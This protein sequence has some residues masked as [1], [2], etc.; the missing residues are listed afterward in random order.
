MRTPN[1]GHAPPC[2]SSFL[3][4]GH[5]TACT[6]SPVFREHRMVPYERN[7]TKRNETSHPSPFSCRISDRH[8]SSSLFLGGATAEEPRHAPVKTKQ[9]TTYILF[10][11]SVVIRTTEREREQRLERL[12]LPLPPRDCHSVGGCIFLACPPKDVPLFPTDCRPLRCH[13]R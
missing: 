5:T 2:R 4:G 8:E 1:V 7:E 13:R 6:A 3:L 12:L 11:N 9:K 10:W